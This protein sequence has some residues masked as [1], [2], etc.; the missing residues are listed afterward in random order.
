MCLV[1]HTSV[2]AANFSNSKTPMGPFQMMVLVVSRASLNV[3]MESGPISRPIQPSGMAVAGTICKSY[4]IV[5][6]LNRQDQML[7]CFIFIHDSLRANHNKCDSYLA[8]S[9]RSKLV[10]NNHIGWEQERDTFGL[11]LLHE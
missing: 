3:L 2:P 7:K 8:V 1:A 11:C 9:I 4:I 10:S 6:V 5:S